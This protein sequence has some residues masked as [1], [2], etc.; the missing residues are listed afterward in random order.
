MSERNI[1]LSPFG[2]YPPAIRYR[3]QRLL[4]RCAIKL[5]IL[6]LIVAMMSLA[7]CSADNANSSTA[8]KG[9]GFYFGGSVGAA[10]TKVLVH[11]IEVSLSTDFLEAGVSYLMEV[12]NDL[13][14][15]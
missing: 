9:K 3:W 10:S 6:A 8:S 12:V 2:Y 11:G 4:S 15:G 7:G 5:A 14:I 13:R 1:A